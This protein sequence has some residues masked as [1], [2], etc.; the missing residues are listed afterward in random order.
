ME[1]KRYFS[2]IQFPARACVEVDRER[3][4]AELLDICLKGALVRFETEVPLRKG[5]AC[6]LEINL[7]SSEIT[8]TFDVKVVH[9][10]ENNAG[11]KFSGIDADTMTHLRRLLELNTGDPEQIAGELA[12]W[13]E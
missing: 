2:R 9:L 3:H 5:S 11:F 13:L 1:D 8:L 7:P 4:P 10:H 12:F 6:V